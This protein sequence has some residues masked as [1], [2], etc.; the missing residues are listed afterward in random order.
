M[1]LL[2]Q[3]PPPACFAFLNPPL[4]TPLLFLLILL[5]PLP[6]FP[7]L[8]SLDDCPLPLD[9]LR[10]TR[11]CLELDLSNKQLSIASGMVVAA[12]IA[13]NQSLASLR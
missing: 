3:L 6:F 12:S 5:Y 11:A 4:P 8:C 7:V 1:T 2:P 13:G 9:V 10:G